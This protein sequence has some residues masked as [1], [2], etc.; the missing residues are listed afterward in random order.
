M[1]LPPWLGRS[2]HLNGIECQ[3]G[4]SP[5]V[6]VETCG[7][8]SVMNGARWAIFVAVVLTTWTLMNGYVFWR[9][10]SVPWVA[11][12]VPRRLLIAVAAALWLSYPVARILGGMHW[13][14]VSIPLEYVGAIWVGT[15]F[16]LLMALL[17]VEV[18]TLCGVLWPNGSPTIRGVAALVALVLAV[19]AVIQGR[20]PPVM[21]TQE[22]TLPG[23]P[24]ELD[25]TTMAVIS[26]VHLGTLNR[27]RWLARVIGRVN[28][29]KPDLV[30]VVG[31][32][33]D[34]N[35]D[36]IEDLVP[37]LRDLRAPLGTWAVTGNHEF[38]AGLDRSVDFLGDCGFHVL[39]DRWEQPKPGLVIVGVDDLPT[40]RQWGE[41]GR[42]LED[43]LNSLPAGGRILLSHSPVEAE[44]AAAAGIGLMLSGH[45]HNGQIWPF[46]HIVAMVY[47]RICGTYQING[48]TLIVGR[49]TGTWGPPMRLWR[50]SEWYRITLR[51]AA[52]GDHS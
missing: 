24:A 30:M 39:R 18:V 37:T 20:R 11:G 17:L 36:H 34:G 6:G 35:V 38:Y 26:D 7:I 44:K 10:A 33:V 19:I 3:P 52:A 28:A 13:T 47:P 50:P 9:L 48:M 27:Q 42:P 49:G 40:R 2:L 23:L 21:R 46:T 43:A 12:H 29:E 32:L 25:G 5:L 31:D 4:S 41:P 16:L 45:T 51:S 22:V 1:V 14:R 8:G 15:L